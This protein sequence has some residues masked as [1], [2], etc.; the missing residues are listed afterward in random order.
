MR[1]KKVFKPNENFDIYLLTDLLTKKIV[2]NKNLYIIDKIYTQ[3]K[4]F[5]IILHIDVLLVKFL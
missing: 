4:K 2:N 5:N 1:T 3:N